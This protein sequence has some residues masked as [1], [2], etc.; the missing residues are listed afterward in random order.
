MT[1]GCGLLV[2]VVSLVLR[3]NCS[4]GESRTALDRVR[5]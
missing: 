3:A 5:L 1:T 2:Y 4:G